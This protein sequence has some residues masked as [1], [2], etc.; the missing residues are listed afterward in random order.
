MG[1]QEV[2]NHGLQKPLDSLITWLSATH[3]VFY[4]L[5]KKQL[6]KKE[7]R[8]MFVNAWL[9]NLHATSSSV[10]LPLCFLLNAPSW[11]VIS[12]IL[13]PLTYRERSRKIPVSKALRFFGEAS[14]SLSRR[15]SQPELLNTPLWV[16]ARF[17]WITKW[18]GFLLTSRVI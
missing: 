11:S 16:V 7:Y 5:I 9:I 14:W 6:F 10:M 17:F 12:S 13:F 15:G 3:H 8:N 4:I 2:W 18:L 1:H